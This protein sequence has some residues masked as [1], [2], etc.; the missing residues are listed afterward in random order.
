MLYALKPTFNAPLFQGA[1]ITLMNQQK[2]PRFYMRWAAC[3]RFLAMAVLV[4]GCATITADRA[5]A[6]SMTSDAYQLNLENLDQFR[7][8]ARE[9]RASSSSAPADASR[10]SRLPPLPFAAQIE[11]AA[12][13]AAIDPALVHALIYVESRHNPVARSTKGALGLMQVL[14]ETASRY[15]VTNAIRSVDENLRAGTSYLRDLMNLFDGRLDLVL[16]AYNAGE[17]AVLRYGLRIPPYR[18]TQQYV[19]AVLQKY[20]EWREPDPVESRAPRRVVYLTGT[21]LE[22]AALLGVPR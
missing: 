12:K 14:P 1:R 7:L 22:S 16:A 9:G 8:S 11:S 4:V 21:R 5:G 3:Q 10:S 6:Q 2:K 19:P 20:R 15:G 18:E 17:N 13:A